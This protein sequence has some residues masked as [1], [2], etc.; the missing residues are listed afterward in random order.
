M[1]IFHP[2]SASV[3]LGYK[4]PFFFVFRM[5]PYF[6]LRYPSPYL[7]EFLIK[8]HFYCFNYYQGRILSLFLAVSPVPQ[9]GF[10]SLTKKAFRVFK[11][12]KLF[13]KQAFS[14]SGQMASALLRWENRQAQR[15]QLHPGLRFCFPY[16]N[17][18]R[19]IARAVCDWCGL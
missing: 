11:A 10:L 1:V 16:L 14:S 7:Q 18:S 17:E 3:T 8:I 6:I 13:S 9:P 2:L 19:V 4:S 15:L 12:F 5:E